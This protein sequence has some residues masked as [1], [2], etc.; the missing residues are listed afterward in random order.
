MDSNSA[1]EA[2][3]VIVAMVK[4]TI[5]AYVGNAIGSSKAGN[6][7]MTPTMIPSGWFAPIGVF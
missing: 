3:K 6:I 1:N 7:G 5:I 4:S 2:S